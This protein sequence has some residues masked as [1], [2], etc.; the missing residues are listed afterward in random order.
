MKLIG[1]FLTLLGAVSIY[2]SHSNQNLLSH[3]LPALFKYLGLVLLSVGLIALF[4]SLPK[5]VA[6]FCWFMLIIFAWSFLPFIALFKRKLV[7]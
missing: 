2:C 5:V 6:A 1:L 7:S 4:A 3:H